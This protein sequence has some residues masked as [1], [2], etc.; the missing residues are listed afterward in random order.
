MSEEL[1]SAREQQIARIVSHNNATS[2]LDHDAYTVPL[3][4]IT[5]Q[6]PT[7][8]ARHDRLSS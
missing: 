7:F 1:V 4:C 6:A 2:H 3:L 8:G 5:P